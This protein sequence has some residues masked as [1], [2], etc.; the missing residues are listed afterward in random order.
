MVSDA[1]RELFDKAILFLTSIKFT[2]SSLNDEFKSILRESKNGMVQATSY[3]L[4]K[5]LMVL[6]CIYIICLFA[7]VIP[8]FAIQKYSWSGFG[9]GTLLWSVLFFCFESVAECLA[10]WVDDP[11]IGMMQFMN[12]WL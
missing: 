3:V 9:A 2:C 1:S 4:A 12:F 7:L 8:A 11:I 10:V 6:P 5:S